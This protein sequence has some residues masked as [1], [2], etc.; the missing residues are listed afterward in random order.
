MQFKRSAGHSDL[1][2]AA[3]C[4]LSPTFLWGMARGQFDANLGGALA[5]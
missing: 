4:A 3:A 2:M 5:S 1:V